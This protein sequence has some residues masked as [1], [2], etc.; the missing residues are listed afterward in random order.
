MIRGSDGDIYFDVKTDEQTDLLRSLMNDTETGKKAVLKSIDFFS[1]KEGETFRDLLYDAIETLF[2]V[3]N[4]HI[5]VR[6]AEAALRNLL[7]AGEIH[8]EDEEVEDDLLE[9]PVEDLTPRDRNGAPLNSSQLA[10]RE[11]GEWSA[12]HSSSECKLRAR[13][14]D[15]YGV[16]FRKQFEREFGATEVGD[17]VVPAGQSSRSQAPTAELR[18]FARQYLVEKSDNLRPRNGLVTLA[19]RQMAYAHFNTLVEQASAAGL[20]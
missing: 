6:Q 19:G 11:F 9:E 5:S 14:D 17:A 12:S 3:E 7:L 2:V 13:S 8:S 20:L 16:F 10:W 4:E 15:A 1:H 18:D